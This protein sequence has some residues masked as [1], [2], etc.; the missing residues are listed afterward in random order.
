LPANL[1]AHAKGLWN[2]A[3]QA[4]TVEEKIGY[5]RNSYQRFQSTKATR[6]SEHKSS[7][8]LPF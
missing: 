8:R 2:K 5:F 3:I 4:R 7:A 6:G 1:T